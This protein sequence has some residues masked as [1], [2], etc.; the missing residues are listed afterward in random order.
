M[1][2]LLVSALIVGVVGCARRAPAPHN[3]AEPSLVVL[4]QPEVK[5]LAEQHCAS[6]HQG[7]VSRAK[8]EAL[9]V[10]DLDQ[11]SWSAGLSAAQYGVFYQ[12]MAGE[13]DPATRAR[14]QDYTA[15]EAKRVASR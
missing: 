14:L 2:S 4:S 15:R 1:R 6:C 8:P 10:F 7:S 3:A 5:Q 11:P 13:L 9:A 12:R